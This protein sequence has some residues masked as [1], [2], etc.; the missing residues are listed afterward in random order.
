MIDCAFASSPL[1]GSDLR[2]QGYIAW[3]DL[4]AVEDSGSSDNDCNS[5][6]GGEGDTGDGEDE[7]D[8]WEDEPAEGEEIVAVAEDEDE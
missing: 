5:E 8:E 3:S 7:E 6:D 1:A 2:V 4:A